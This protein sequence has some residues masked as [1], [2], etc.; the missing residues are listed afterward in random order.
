MSGTERGIT[1]SSQ[2]DQGFTPDTPGDNGSAIVSFP[3]HQEAE[4]VQSDM[5]AAR[6]RASIQPQ[7]R[8]RAAVALFNN[9]EDV[10]R[11]LELTGTWR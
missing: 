6:V 3:H 8:L 4:R 5:E 11:F 9:D 10:D 2:L 1:D 7:G